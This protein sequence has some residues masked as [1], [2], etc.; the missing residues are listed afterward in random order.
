MAKEKNQLYYLKK[1][2]K[3]YDGYKYKRYFPHFDTPIYLAAYS[4]ETIGINFINKITKSNQNFINVLLNI[5]RD[6]FYSMYFASFKT[7]YSNTNF[8]YDKIIFTWAFKKDFKLDGTLQDKYLNIN[9]KEVKNTLWFVIYL[10]TDFPKKVRKNIFLFQPISKKK[11]SITQIIKNVFRNLRYLFRDKNYF[12]FNMSNY[13]FLSQK[14]SKVFLKI[15]SDDVKKVLLLYEGQPF[16]NEVVRLSKERHNI[17][18]LGYV[19]APPIAFPANYIKKKFS[20]DKIFLAGQDQIRIFLKLGWGKKDLILCRSRRFFKNNNNQNRKIFL[21]LNIKSEVKILNNIDYI[22][23]IY[24]LNK[25]DIQLH[26]ATEK[27]KR[28]INLK[29]RIL[30]I[31]ESKGNGKKISNPIFIGATGS[32][33]EFLENNFMK[34]IHITENEIMEKYSTIIWPSLNVKKIKSNIF[35]YQIKKKNRLLKLGSKQKNLNFFLN[36]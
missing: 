10:D 22:S 17:K 12:L 9:S 19:H 24:N 13:N 14:I 15:L 30:K 29:K 3:F 33:I 20:P 32:I 21:P 11:F 7:L 18:T 28:N 1:I 34:A 6:S 27:F 26:P 2:K 31:I 25:Y 5:V 23:K 36:K 4:R 35:I 16:Q 8:F